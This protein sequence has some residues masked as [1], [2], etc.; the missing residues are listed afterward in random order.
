[1]NYLE[2]RKQYVVVED[3]K[4][5]L[6]DIMCGV[7]QGSILGS[8]LFNVYINEIFNLK[9]KGHLQ[10]YADDGVLTYGEPTF[11]D[12]KSSMT[13]DLH[14]I[15]NWLLQF[16]L[17]MNL[18]KT[19][20]LIFNSSSTNCFSSSNTLHSID[21]Y[22][23]TISTV[24][25]FKYLGLTIDSSLS[26]KPHITAI[27]KKIAP[28][29]GM[30]FRLRKFVCQPTLY[31]I[32]YAFIDSRL[33]YCLPIWGRANNKSLNMLQTL[34]NKSIKIITKKPRLTPTDDIYKE[35]FLS[36]KQKIQYE[37]VLTIIKIMNKTLHCTV[38]ISTNYSTTNIATRNKDLLRAPN[39]YTKFAQKSF[40][41]C[42][43]AL[44]NNLPANIKSE[45]NLSKLKTMLKVY[46]FKTISIK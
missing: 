28:Y 30:L 4:S 44:Y 42:G 32:Y 7:P 22:G 2:N 25:E 26:W 11:D 1:M 27:S 13:N 12:L 18:A 15:Y 34:Q 46:V 35:S 20:I 21:M 6:M 19:K 29:I 37:T 39:F 16:N 23:E 41:Y 5:E 45:N 36:F 9:I 3:N 10:L 43:V 33:T 40:I 8:L 14:K 31:K 38:F 17:V 24:T